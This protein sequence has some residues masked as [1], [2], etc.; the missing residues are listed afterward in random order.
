MLQHAPEV[1]RDSSNPLD[2]AIAKTVAYRDLFQYPVT[3]HEIH[4][5]LH[6]VR[7]GQDAVADALVTAVDYGTLITDG[8]YFAL[9]G[10][11]GLFE[12]RLQRRATSQSL[13]NL[14]RGHAARLAAL[15][16]VRMVGVTGSLA[17]DNATDDADIDFMLITD[18]G[19]LWTARAF[20][21]FLQ[22]INRRVGD[23]KLCV[24][25]LVSTKRLQLDEPGLYIAQELSQ[26]VPLYGRDTYNMLREANP[27]VDEILPNA[28]GLPREAEQV[29]PASSSFKQAAKAILRTPL[30]T[31][32]ERFESKRKL[33]KYN[34]TPFLLG[35]STPF[36]EEATGHRRTV[37]ST[38]ESAFET[39]CAGRQQDR[40]RILFG[41]AYHLHLDPKLYRDMQPFPPLGSL[42]AA[43]IARELGHDVVVHDSMLATSV[44]D[45]TATVMIH[46]PDV[47]VL[48]ED[49][50]NYLTKMCLSNMREAGM[51]MV[52]AAK[53]T[54]ARVVVC[55]SDASDNADIYLDAGADVVLI[56][57]GEE[58]LQDVLVQFSSDSRGNLADLAGVAFRG[59]NGALVV[60]PRRPVIRNLDELPHP[61][62]DLIDLDRY[63]EIGQRKRGL[64]SINLVTTRGCPYHCNWC[65]KP[66]W[67]QRYNA[68]S[69]EDVV[70]EIRELKGRIDFD[71]VWFM[72]DIFG[73]K[74]RW[75]SQFANELDANGLKI[76][77]K[78]LSR[79]DLL[80][81]DGEVEALARSGCDVVWMGAESGSQKILDAMEKGTTVEMIRES[82]SQL[83]EHGISVGLFI[84]F[85][86][87][88]E[89]RADIRDTI[90]LIRDL[91]PEQL[92]ISVSYPLP[93]TRFYDR[94]SAE[95]GEVRNW[96]DSDDLAMLFKGPYN[97]TFYRA[98]H[99][100]VHAD[101]GVR[102]AA[103]D[104]R[105][106]RNL[107]KF[108]VFSLKRAAYRATM[109]VA[110]LMPH[111]G[112]NPLAAELS[113][114][115]A[116][117]PSAQ[118]DK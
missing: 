77:Y 45:W 13:W 54:G 89:N 87:P 33:H 21:K 115:A 86:Y 10:R 94:V 51:R 32:I 56:G 31:G 71:Y 42:Y 30:G 49:N 65:A 107:A 101:L 52:S 114:D 46:E 39:R 61:A 23:G 43:A 17:V 35:R 103:G 5:Y 47:A 62:W 60:T 59:S 38:I 66:V 19:R 78:C 82:S 73:L 53:A 34:E 24:N 69:P 83:R 26:M 50:F 105:S 116:A 108:V 80:L 6:E 79:P 41:Q 14:A 29:E 20:A 3:A 98:L 7:C 40:L 22:M 63:T 111:K 55:S 109:E 112:L 70:S 76:R 36:H 15:P 2:D 106:L 81:R 72:D 9:P 57:E 90:R 64:T 8:T 4:R 118:P 104:P 92:G 27:W 91:M 96:S 84:Q 95:L 16:F 85:G 117:T 100:Y 1:G 44:S 48:Y 28:K 93:G 11:E 58:T 74:P 113:P 67:G 97:T 18:G 110:A 75:I 88:G 99:R 37:R 25:H 102:R 12:R 68:R